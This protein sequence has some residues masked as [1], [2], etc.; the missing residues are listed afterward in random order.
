MIFVHLTLKNSAYQQKKQKSCT[1]R[2]LYFNTDFLPAEHAT[3][4]QTA[5]SLAGPAEGQ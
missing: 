4:Q 3:V 2:H 1:Q 5:V